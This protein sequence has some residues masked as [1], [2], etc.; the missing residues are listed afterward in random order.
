MNMLVQAPIPT[1]FGPFAVFNGVPEA[2]RSGSPETMVSLLD[3]PAAFVVGE[4]QETTR[5]VSTLAHGDESSSI[6]ALARI[7]KERSETSPHADIIYL[8]GNVRAA[9]GG[10]FFEERTLQAGK[11]RWDYNRIWD[12]SK[13]LPEGI[14]RLRWGILNLLKS[15]RVELLID[16]H[17]NSADNPPYVLMY[18]G[19]GESA[20]ISGFFGR[21]AMI[22]PS[23]AIL[24]GAMEILLG[25][26]SFSLECGK[27]GEESSHRTAERAIR[28]VIDT[29]FFEPDPPYEFY[30]EVAEVFLVPGAF[31]VR[32]DIERL[33]F[34]EPGFPKRIGHFEGTAWPIR[35]DRGLHPGDLFDRDEMGNLFLQ[36]GYTVAMATFEKKNLPDIFLFMVLR[37]V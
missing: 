19:G 1:T 37:K 15:R 4:G 33:N 29:P 36:A 12:F 28:K 30:E 35:L 8:V 6:T 5:V 34:S 25:A 22:S 26:P 16:L 24:S 23:R 14:D 7:F 20:E 13:R 11:Q 3:G 10:D 21:K 9:R 2:F 17:N 27:T 32:P 31:S 18:A